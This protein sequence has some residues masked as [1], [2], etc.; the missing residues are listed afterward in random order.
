MADGYKTNER[1]PMVGDDLDKMK[2]AKTKLI[3]GITNPLP[4]IS[5]LDRNDV[6]ARFHKEMINTK[7]HNE[8]KTRLLI[9]TLMT[10]C[11]GG[12]VPFIE[13]LRETDHTDLADLLVN[14]PRTPSNWKKGELLG[15]GGFAHVYKCYDMDTGREYAVKM[16]QLSY[17]NT[18]PE[19]D[20]LA[21]DGLHLLK[22]LHDERIVQ[23]YGCQRDEKVLSLFMEYMPGGS[24]RDLINEIGGIQEPLVRKYSRQVLQGLSYLHKNNI[25]HRDIKADNIFRDAHD[26]VKLGEFGAAKRLSAA[27]L[28]MTVV[29]TPH[30]MAPEVINSKGYG[31]EADIWSFGGTIVEMLSTKPPFHEYEP[32]AAMFQIAKCKHPEYELPNNVTGKRRNKPNVFSNHKFCMQALSVP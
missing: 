3:A 28:E 22:S 24:V 14:T 23:Y 5:C 21:L 32:M 16:T 4:I 11:K 15:R 7:E 6:L 2:Q 8:E 30:W 17:L 31:R 27:I 9:D 26:N 10:D 25:V 29:G 1:G 19:M 13:S 18:E 12:F 20:V